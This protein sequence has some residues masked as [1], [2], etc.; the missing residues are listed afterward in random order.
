MISNWVVGLP[1]L[2]IQQCWAVQ[3]VTAS[4]AHRGEFAEYAIQRRDLIN[5]LLLTTFPSVVQE[6]SGGYSYSHLFHQKCGPCF[7]NLQSH[8]FFSPPRCVN[9]IWWNLCALNVHLWLRISCVSKFYGLLH[10]FSNIGCVL[11]CTHHGKSL[12]IRVGYL[13]VL[14]FSLSRSRNLRSGKMPHSDSAQITWRASIWSAIHHLLHGRYISC[15]P[16]LAQATY[17]CQRHVIQRS[18]VWLSF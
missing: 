12:A 9:S 16:T 3:Y 13:Q 10:L 15:S 14:I 7:Q 5:H 18:Q 6:D 1:L 2:L 17:I 8:P 4:F 11:M